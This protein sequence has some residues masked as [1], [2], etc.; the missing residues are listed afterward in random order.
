MLSCRRREDECRG[1]TRPTA[2]VATV[3]PCSEPPRCPIGQDTHHAL[4]DCISMRQVHGNLE[5][6]GAV[7]SGD[8]LQA[9]WRALRPASTLWLLQGQCKERSVPTSRPGCWV[10]T[11][12]P[13]P[14]TGTL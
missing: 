12:S 7:H 5:I 1:Q 10:S 9:P 4:A 8:V 3:P 6:W 2:R 13:P 14:T 11:Q